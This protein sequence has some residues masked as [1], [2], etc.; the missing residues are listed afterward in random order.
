MKSD[1]LVI[2]AKLLVF[3]L[4]L[5]L[6]YSLQ[7]CWVLKN[8]S[9]LMFEKFWKRVGITPTSYVL[10]CGR[11][12]FASDGAYGNTAEGR[13]R[14]KQT[15]VNKVWSEACKM[16]NHTVKV[17]NSLLEDVLMHFL[18]KLSIAFYTLKRETDTVLRILVLLLFLLE[19]SHF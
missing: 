16:H 1:L 13:L 9:I 2:L 8:C 10:Q 12:P 14:R 7:M 19:Q 17:T 15:Q 5:I 4:W 18:L 6:V 3:Y 11:E